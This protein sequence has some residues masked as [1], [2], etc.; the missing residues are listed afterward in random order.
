M[1]SIRPH[2]CACGLAAALFVWAMAAHAAG[3][4]GCGET[5]R[6]ELQHDGLPRTYAVHVPQSVCDGQVP[7]PVVFGLHCL[8]CPPEYYD[9]LR[10][11]TEPSAFVLVIPA[12]WELSW[13]A[14]ACCGARPAPNPLSH[15]RV[16]AYLSNPSF[17]G[18]VLRVAWFTSST[19]CE[20][21]PSV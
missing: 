9:K 4:V 13:N 20:A 3:G 21:M 8:G 7:A 5:R 16:C 18:K 12:G 10:R 19:C 15:V 11:Y 1:P 17:P 6:F 14:G 2:G